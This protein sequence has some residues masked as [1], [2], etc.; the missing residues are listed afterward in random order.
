MTAANTATHRIKRVPAAHPHPG[1]DHRHHLHAL[2]AHLHEQIARCD[3]SGMDDFAVEL[4]TIRDHVSTPEWRLL[5]DEVVAPHPLRARL[6]EEPFTNRAFEKPRGY[7][8]D[9]PLLDLIYRDAT[10]TGPLTTLGTALHSWIGT[11]HPACRSVQER[12]Q[13]LATLIDEVAAERKS[14]RMLSL[15]CGHLREAQRSI[16]VQERD[17]EAFIAIDQDRESLAVIER[18]QRAFNVVPVASSVRRFLVAPTVHGSF[19][20][21][22]SAGLY[23]YLGDRG[24]RQRFRY[25][26]HS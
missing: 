10:Y 17:V 13:L 24:T 8:G 1:H 26:P 15:A 23:D 3:V 12:R 21:A 11:G 7:P 6:Q 5:L 14:P 16:A 2:V 22:Y 19:D 20:L 9:A 4:K 25:L 18:E